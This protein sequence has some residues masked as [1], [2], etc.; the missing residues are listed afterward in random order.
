MTIVFCAMNRTVLRKMIR[1]GLWHTLGSDH[2]YSTTAEAVTA[3]LRKQVSVPSPS[4][5]ETIHD[6]RLHIPYLSHAQV[7]DAYQRTMFAK[8]QQQQQQRLQQRRWCRQQQQQQQQQRQHQQQQKQQ[9]QQ[10]MEPNDDN[11]NDKNNNTTALSSNNN[12]MTTPGS[13]D[14]TTGAAR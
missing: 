6:N 3:L 1:C 14:N 10:L 13:N 4:N 5:Y 9:K 8:Q 2:F 11:D 12:T 7:T